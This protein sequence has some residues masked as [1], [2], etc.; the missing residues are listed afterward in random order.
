MGV[1]VSLT[2]PIGNTTSA[3][4]SLNVITHLPTVGISSGIFGD[5][6]LNIAE[7]GVSQLLTGT[8]TSALPGAKVVVTVGTVDYQATVNANGT[9]S[10]NLTSTQLKSLT[11]GSLHIGV[12]VTDVVGNTNSTGVDVGIKLSQPLLGLNVVTLPSLGDLL[13]GGKLLVITGTSK[14]CRTA[15]RFTFRC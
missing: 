4:G 5:G 14:T 6:I 2:N 7:S 15:P 10:L 11:D 9:W 13:L 1:N 12:K 3:G 8:V